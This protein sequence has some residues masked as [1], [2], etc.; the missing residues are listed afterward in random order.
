MFFLL[1]KHLDVAADTIV[2]AGITL[3]WHIDNH[4]FGYT[5]GDT[6]LNHFLALFHTR[7]ATLMTFVLDHLTFTAADRTDALLLHH[8][9]NALGGVGDDTRSVTGLTSLFAAAVFCT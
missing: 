9:E 5:S 3:A 7:T 1:D 2:F 6:D 4:T 8:A